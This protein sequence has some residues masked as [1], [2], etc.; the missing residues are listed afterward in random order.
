MQDPSWIKCVWA[1]WNK[2][3]KSRERE[4][5]RQCVEDRREERTREKE[6]KNI[7]GGK[8][9]TTKDGQKRTFRSEGRN[10]MKNLMKTEVQQIICVC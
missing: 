8:K 10:M 2:R 9:V 1:A 7:Q 3:N 6:E 5:G 4:K